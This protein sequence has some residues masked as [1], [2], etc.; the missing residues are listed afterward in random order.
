MST[1]LY[2]S[3][4]RVYDLQHRTFADDLPL[5][6]Q[7]ARDLPPGGAILEFGC[8]TGRVMLPLLQAGFSVTGVD[9]SAGMLALARAQLGPAAELIQADT[10][11]LALG[12]R[13][14][15]VFIALNTFLHNLTRED[16]L[17]TLRAARAHLRPGGV[18]LIDLPPNDELSFQP[19]DNQFEVEATLVDPESGSR[20]TKHV[21]SSLDWSTQTQTL[22]YRIEEEREGKTQTQNVSFALRHV[23]KHEMELLMLAAGFAAP[24]W[25]GDYQRHPYERDSTRMIALAR[26]V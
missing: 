21:A 1:P 15:L 17:A 12:P 3:F 22:T 26:A 10:R 11:A 5:Y 6:A 7:V 2:D 23:F 4:A 20:V 24:E 18:L 19:D 9:E 8:G 14:A 25:Y 13:F 16:Q